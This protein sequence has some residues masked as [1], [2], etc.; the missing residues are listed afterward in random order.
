MIFIIYIGQKI[1]DVRAHFTIIYIEQKSKYMT[2]SCFDY[3]LNYL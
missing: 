1:K 3:N 2:K